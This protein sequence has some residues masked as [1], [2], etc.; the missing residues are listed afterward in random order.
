MV[1][2]SADKFDVDKKAKEV[3][4]RFREGRKNTIRSLQQDKKSG[5]VV[6][7][8]LLLSGDECGVCEKN[9][10][11]FFPIATCTPEM[12]PPYENCEDQSGCSGCF[13]QV[14]ISDPAPVLSKRK[15]CLGAVLVLIA[16][17]LSA[18]GLGIYS[19]CMHRSMSGQ[20]ERP[21]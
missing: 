18:T 17:M 8:R 4:E 19:T 21:R 20:P 12:L 11:G 1:P 14:L 9:K 15:G 10:D 2:E 16:F 5:V 6:G 13:V 3:N 7:Y